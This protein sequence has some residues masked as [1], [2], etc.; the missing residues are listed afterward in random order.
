MK[1]TL[2]FSVL[3][4]T[5]SAFADGDISSAAFADENLVAGKMSDRNNNDNNCCKPCKPCDKK[6][7]IMPVVLTTARPCYDAGVYLFADALYWYTDVGTND[8]AFVNS[9]T[10]TSVVSGSGQHA[11]Y[12]W[13]WGF[14]AGIGFDMGHDQWDTNFYY[15]WLRA[16]TSSNGTSF[17]V[18]APALG[19]DEV[20]VAGTYTAGSSSG[21]FHFNVVDWELGRWFYISQSISLR[22][23][24][25]A[26]GAW[27]TL[28]ETE[29]YTGGAATAS[30][31]SISNHSKSWAVGP[32]AGLNT[33]WWFGNVNNHHF[34]IFGDFS[35]SLL[36]SQFKNSF[37]DTVTTT[38]VTPGAGGLS[39]SSKHDNTAIPVMTALMGLGWDTCFSC[40]TMH[41][42]IRV[43]YEF[44]YWFN[45]IQ[46]TKVTSRVAAATPLEQYQRVTN[47]L[48]LQGLTI[49]VRFDF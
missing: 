2:L 47:N 43:G 42:G 34:S 26:K 36:F 40:E 27:F 6:P 48:A 1:K 7:P 16:K 21:K 39:I 29:S 32:S 12:K 18:A 49:D 23:H 46:R 28:S 17:S 13:N 25:G 44:Q 33:N 30:A 38:S 8:W 35:S 14:R 9:N 3:A 45:Q 20:G 11:Q 31:A 37:S 22:P 10:T 4:L 15:T 5:A 24:V 41:L 19:I